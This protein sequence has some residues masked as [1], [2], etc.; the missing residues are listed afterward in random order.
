MERQKYL[1]IILVLFAQTPLIGNNA[2]DYKIYKAYIENDMQEWQ[3]IIDTMQNG[4]EKSHDILS[5]LINFQYGYIAWCIG[6]DHP[7]MAKKYLAIAEKNLDLLPKEKYKATIS[8]YRSAF[9]GF[10]IGLNK[11][12]APIY[13][14][15]SVR[16]AEQAIEEDDRNPMGYIQ[17]GNTQY[18]MPAIFGGSKKIAIKYFQKA[19]ILM[20]SNRELIKYDWNYLS[21]LTLIAQSFEEIGETEQAHNYYQ[22][23]LLIEPEFLWVRNELYPQFLKKLKHTQ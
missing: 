5:T 14:P 10:R 12:R 6:N 2:W 13:G 8:A 1:L 7:G 23:I 21:L 20:E 18:Y 11:I 15:R 19:E 4:Q 3:R 22:K 9:Y 17:Y 16:H